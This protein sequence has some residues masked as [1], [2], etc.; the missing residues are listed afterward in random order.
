MSSGSDKK[1]SIWI[2]GQSQENNFLGSFEEDFVAANLQV[3]GKNKKDE[4]CQVIYSCGQYIKL[5]SFK[6]LTSG[7]VYKNLKEITSLCIVKQSPHIVAFGT[8]SGA[9]KDFDMKS[10]KIV[11]TQA[12]RHKKSIACLYSQG[13]YLVSCSTDDNL[14]IVYDYSK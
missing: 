13:K 7:I 10:K 6:S 11:R 4:E 1:L 2:P 9:I 3:F 8:V 14:I 12:K 5:L